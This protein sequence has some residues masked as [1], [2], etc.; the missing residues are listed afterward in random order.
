MI[1]KFAIMCKLKLLA[2]TRNTLLNF[3]YKMISIIF[4]MMYF[5][6]KH[7]VGSGAVKKMLISLLRENAHIPKIN[8]P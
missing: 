7:S 1:K 5:K 8:K 6:T 3:V 2:S 4:E